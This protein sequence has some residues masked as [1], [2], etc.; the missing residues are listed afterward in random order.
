MLKETACLESKYLMKSFEQT[1]VNFLSLGFL[2]DENT[3][4][5]FLS[6]GVLKFYFIVL[7]L[8]T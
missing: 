3:S 5:F 7:S 8:R 6:R 2:Q 1:I 4:M